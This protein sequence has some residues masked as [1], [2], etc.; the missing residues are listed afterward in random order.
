MAGVSPTTVSNVLNGTKP[1][2]PEVAERVL[3]AVEMLGYRPNR[4][5]R[6]LRT[7]RSHTLGLV[8]PDLKNPFFP[9]LAQSVTVAARE[10]GF[11]VLLV[12]AL[13]DPLAEA[14]GFVLLEEHR[15]EGAIWAPVNSFRPLAFP[16]V[17]IDRLAP[18]W[19]GVG[20]DHLAG[21]RLQAQHAAALGHRRV[22]IIRGPSNL[23]SAILRYQGFLEE[24]KRLNLEVVWEYE[25][26]FDG[27]LSG[28]VILSLLKSNVTFVA[29]ANDLLAINLLRLLAEAG[30]KVPDRISVIG[31]DDIPWA[32]FTEPPLTTVRQ[33][34]KELGEVALK[35]L[36]RRIRDPG[37]PPKQIRLPV[38][39]VLRFSTREV[40]Q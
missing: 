30:V 12:D 6:A 20:A 24:A 35:L 29:C 33:P 10:R 27:R 32:T 21:G 18:G 13:E 22:G 4:S 14:E 3:A 28:D 1:V 5:A 7:G 16:T 26:S 36:L 2:R 17:L 11:G 39:L 40:V 23:D 19:D 25:A 9:E 38:E 34:L 37:A 31:Y 15:I 8:I